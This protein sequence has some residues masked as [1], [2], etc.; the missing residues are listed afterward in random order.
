[1][2]QG[3][4][5][6]VALVAALAAI[7]C[8]RGGRPPVCAGRVRRAV[9]AGSSAG[10]DGPACAERA[11]DRRLAVPSR[12]S[13]VFAEL[14][15]AARAS[16]AKSAVGAPGSCLA[17]VVGRARP[18]PREI[19]VSCALQADGRRH[20]CA[21]GGPGCSGRPLRPRGGVA[22]CAP[23]GF[24]NVRLLTGTSRRERRGTSCASSGV[25]S[26]NRPSAV[27]SSTQSLVITLRGY[28]PTMRGIVL[29]WESAR[30]HPSEAEHAGALLADTTRKGD[31]AMRDTWT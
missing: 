7:A 23:P 19:P 28:M 31:S 10:P 25:N 24:E 29:V 30:R 13:A 22:R 14:P 18:Q 26:A 16:S 4:K 11:V 3:R 27:A 15:R 8:E 21:A 5:R 17:R 12:F 20:S 1:M 6:S 2:A 9:R